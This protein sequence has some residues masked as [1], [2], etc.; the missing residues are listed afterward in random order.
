MGGSLRVRRRPG[1]TASAVV[2]MVSA[3]V[4]T[5]CTEDGASTA[6]PPS[7]SPPGPEAPASSEP[8]DVTPSSG[9]GG[10]GSPQRQRPD[11]GPTAAEW[12]QAQRL[13]SRMSIEELAGGVIMAR[14]T[15]TAAPVALVEDL[16]LAGVIVM[17]DNVAS[18]SGLR[19]T[20]HDLQA[21]VDRP[22]PLAIGVD[23]EGGLVDRVPAPMT[24]YPSYLSVGAAGDPALARRVAAASGAELRA[25]GITMVFGPVADVTIGPADVTIGSRSAGSRPRRVAA[26]V[27]GSV[28]GYAEAGVV[29][30]VKHFPGHG[31]VTVDSHVGLPR[32][33]HSLRW[34]R[35]HDLPPFEAAVRAGVGGVMVGHIAVDRV[36]RGV[37]ADL[38]RDVI[39][40]LRDEVGFGGLVVGDALEMAAVTDRYGT[41]EAAARS[42]AAG[43]DLVLMP[44]DPAEARTA[45]AAA[46]RSGEIPREQVEES[47]ARIGALMLHAAARPEPRPGVLGSHHADSRALSAAAVTVVAGRCRGPYYTRGISVS[48][49]PGLVGSFTRAAAAAGIDVRP[50]GARV[51]LLTARTAPGPAD[52]AVSVD[53]P[54]PLAR[55]PRAATQL[56]L[57]GD[58]PQAWSVLADVLDG[59]LRPT[60]R[61][62]VALPVAGR[63]AR[64]GTT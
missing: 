12:Q 18:V 31:S 9:P 2:A 21:S 38:S 43:V 27:A 15:G 23:Q 41:G 42:V 34:I 33:R 53:V 24:Q 30:V 57:Y 60:G 1:W 55:A 50:G 17:G 62:P 52:V 4:L 19:R 28:R 20:S 29:P 8:S 37:P 46:I 5:A 25:V 51:R 45:I 36:D 63:A 7:T 49:D 26:V 44:L 10:K 59:T 22:W 35:E 16:D 32:Q 48:G 47:V 13:A 11:F 6:S 14:Y 39:A 56:A 3:T 64:C 40:M 58:T 54:Y 61:L